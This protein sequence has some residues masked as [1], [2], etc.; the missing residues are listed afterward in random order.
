MRLYRKTLAFTKEAARQV[1]VSPLQLAV[2]YAHLGDKEQAFA[3]LEKA[4][5]GE[6]P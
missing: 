1:H 2:L 3:F 5:E 6:R 4:F